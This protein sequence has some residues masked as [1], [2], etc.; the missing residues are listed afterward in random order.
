MTTRL[1]RAWAAYA[2]AVAAPLTDVERRELAA[3]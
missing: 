2:R 3:W 1:L